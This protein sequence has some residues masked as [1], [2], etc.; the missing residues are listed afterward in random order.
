MTKSVPADTV[1]ETS[2]FASF[3]DVVLLDRVLV[4]R[5]VRFRI[6]EHPIHSG[7]EL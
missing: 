6:G 4:V 2:E 1:T 7:P 3:P 5:P